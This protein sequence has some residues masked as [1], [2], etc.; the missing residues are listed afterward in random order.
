MQFIQYILNNAQLPSF[1][2]SKGVYLSIKRGRTNGQSLILSFCNSNNDE[3]LHEIELPSFYIEELL[4]EYLSVQLNALGIKVGGLTLVNLSKQLTET[5]TMKYTYEADQGEIAVVAEPAP[6]WGE[7]R[8]NAIPRT[9]R[10]VGR[11]QRT[12]RRPR[13]QTEGLLGP[14]LATAVPEAPAFRRWQEEQQRANAE[15]QAA[16]TRLNNATL[17]RAVGAPAGQAEP[18]PVIGPGDAPGNP[19]LALRP[20]F[21]YGF[22]ETGRADGVAE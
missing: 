11:P 3:V 1:L 21:E 2:L 8:P 16:I 12:G 7:F 10:P 5:K 20:A 4:N 17:A 19:E 14:A 6:L 18:V 9:D 13:L 22:V 15:Y